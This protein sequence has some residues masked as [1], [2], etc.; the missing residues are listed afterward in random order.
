MVFIDLEKAHDGIPQQE[1]C[2]CLR[3]QDVPEKYVRLVEDM[4][5]DE[6][7]QVGTIRPLL[8]QRARSQ[9]VPTRRPTLQ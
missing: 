2:R 8:E 1:V 5:G 4:Y 9:L 6:R 7:T 3:E